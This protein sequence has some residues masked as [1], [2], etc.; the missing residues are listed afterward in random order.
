MSR[1]SLLAAA[2]ALLIGAGALAQAPAPA[3]SPAK[4]ELVAKLLQLQQ[5]DLEVVARGIVQQPAMQMMQQAAPVLQNQ[6]P[7]DKREAAA[8][9]IETDVRR[10]VDETFP[11]V[12]ERAI[13]LA[14]S[15][16]GAVLEDKFS[17]DELKQL[18]AWLE[19]PVNRKFQQASGE[20]RNAFLQ[21][22]VPEARPLMEPKVKALEQSIRSTLGMPATAAGDGPATGGSGPAPAAKPPAPAAKPPARAA[23][24]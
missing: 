12:R 2:G 4:K 11:L 23:S 20:M 5:Q 6:V 13:K 7:A 21:K 17:E 1:K 15:T 9:S 24:R 22:L 14:P 8:K 19:S 18:V 3:A 16:V 10:Y